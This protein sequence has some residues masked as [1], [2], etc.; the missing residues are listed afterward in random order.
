MLCDLCIVESKRKNYVF[1][2]DSK[3]VS[4][5]TWKHP[6]DLGG[7]I[8]QLL[9]TIFG[10]MMEAGMLLPYIDCTRNGSVLFTW[11]EESYYIYVKV[12]P[13]K[14]VRYEVTRNRVIGDDFTWKYIT[15][16]DKLVGTLKMLAKY[17]QGE[18]S[19]A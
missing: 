9:E 17:I 8:L 16:S 4:F 7:E 6:T 18:Q 1:D 19:A 5:Y 11:H 3:C 10:T 15:D 13:G 2:A 14:S 12:I